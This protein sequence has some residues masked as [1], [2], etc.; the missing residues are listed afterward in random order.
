MTDTNWILDAKC[1]Y[2]PL[3]TSD[4]EKEERW[5][6]FH[7]PTPNGEYLER[8]LEAARAFC[9]DGVPCPVREQCLWFGMGDQHGIYAGLGPD[10]RQTLRGRQ[11]RLKRIARGESTKDQRAVNPPKTLRSKRDCPE[12]GRTRSVERHLANGQRLCLGCAEFDADQDRTAALDVRVMAL[13]G[14]GRQPGSI[15]R[16]LGLPRDVVAGVVRKYK[17]RDLRQEVAA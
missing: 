17:K 3:G 14:E 6:L 5:A 11:W 4:K 2:F 10:E 13:A 7:P 15:A 1:A 12:P 9:E 8:D 16:E